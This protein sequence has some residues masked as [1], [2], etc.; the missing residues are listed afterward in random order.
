MG[1]IHE[2]DAA[3]ANGIA[4]GEVVERPS[5][6]VKEL[7]ENAIDAG[8]TVITIEI[9]G[10]GISMIR[11]SDDG[12]GMDEEDARLAFLCHATSKLKTLD[13]LFSLHSMGFRGEALSS[14]AA[15][16]RVNLKTRQPGA[17]TG[18]EVVLEA[19]Q[20]L[21]VMPT[22]GPSGTR[23]EVRD[24]FFNLPARYKFLKKDQTEAQYIAALCE[25][26]A[27]IRPDISFRLISQGKEILHTPGNNDSLSSL[28]CIYGKQI[29]DQCIPINEN[30]GELSIT[31]FAGKPSIA[32]SSR[33]DQ[34]IFVNDRLIRS[35]VISSAIDEAYK[36][37]LMKGR[38]A[39]LILSIRIPSQLLDVNV[40]PQKAEVRFWNDG[41][42][43]RAIFHC[44]HNALLSVPLVVEPQMPFGAAA[45]DIAANHK[46]DIPFESPFMEVPSADSQK[47]ANSDG[48]T[49]PGE[50]S[51]DKSAGIT[52]PALIQMKS[53][54]S[55]P[56]QPR[57]N[58]VT[59]GK[60]TY[61]E[62]EQDSRT[63]IVSHADS[64]NGQSAP[65]GFVMSD[66]LNARII[67]VAFT[68]Y[69]LLEMDRHLVLLD[70]HAAH[71][72]ILF[73]NLV[74]EH[75]QNGTKKI[76]TQPLLVPE[77]LTLT[78]ADML[79]VHEMA[80]LI[81]K[82]GFVFE[83]MGDHEIILREVPAIELPYQPADAFRNTLESL[84]RETPKTDEAMLLILATSACK[85]AVKG[86]DRLDELEIKSLISDLSKLSNP[87]HCPHGRPIIIR[88]SLKDL[89]KE[90][91]RI[92]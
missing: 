26:F 64:A 57:I 40:H 87:Y 91:K 67:G 52:E 21:R 71:E 78:T 3:T 41:E 47:A 89:E 37:M 2:L 29:V 79:F 22:G 5:S 1:L 16:S 12:C 85:A 53:S 11:I 83:P 30:F 84:K 72:K 19:G 70:Q 31:G 54:Y 14:I 32:K 34:I 49:A 33:G 9:T 48:L 13:D 4:A 76:R 77:F 62:D 65:Y 74:K 58:E 82:A 75:E 8:A 55:Y 45:K 61:P 43:F 56:V 23:I 25:R 35:K 10:G 51:P 90:F 38:Y 60:T 50:I 69:I 39:F 15:A 73:E 80:E 7:I 92:V 42:V 59:D 28:Y 68:T 46:E 27:L 18:T 20:T 24:L 36:T 44:L 63:N 88:M 66:L 86:H 6:V 81:E 17:D